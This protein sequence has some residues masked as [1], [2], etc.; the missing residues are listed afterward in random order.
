M[1]YKNVH[2]ALHKNGLVGK[3]WGWGANQRWRFGD[4]WFHCRK[5]AAGIS[6]S[7]LGTKGEHHLL[8]DSS[9]RQTSSKS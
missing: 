2:G 3:T 6:L 1:V 5:W 4:V 9:S 7:S 8:C